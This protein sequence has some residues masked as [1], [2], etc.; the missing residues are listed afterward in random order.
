MRWTH[1]IAVV[2][3]LWRAGV[4]PLAAE[5]TVSVAPAAQPADSAWPAVVPRLASYTEAQKVAITAI[6]DQYCVATRF[7]KR[8]ELHARIQKLLT[9]A[10]LIE[11]IRYWLPQDVQDDVRE[12]Q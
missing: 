11:A 4:A 9:P 10:H 3:I 8:A 12:L 6:V 7:P 1:A 5:T 2:V